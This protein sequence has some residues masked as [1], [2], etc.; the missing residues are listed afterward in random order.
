MIEGISMAREQGHASTVLD[1]AA[2]LSN[3][4]GLAV[5]TAPGVLVSIDLASLMSQAKARLIDCTPESMEAL[6]ND[7]QDRA[8]LDADGK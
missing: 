1:G 8:A 3:L 6:P 2:K 4:L 7:V 5:D